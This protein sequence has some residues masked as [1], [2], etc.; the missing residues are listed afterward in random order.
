MSDSVMDALERRL[1]EQRTYQEVWKQG[2]RVALQALIE[3]GHTGAPRVFD[4][5]FSGSQDPGWLERTAR[6]WIWRLEQ[7]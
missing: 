6:L 4:G 1:Q 2:A 3:E 5:T 7:K